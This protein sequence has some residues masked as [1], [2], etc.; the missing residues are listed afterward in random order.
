[1][2]LLR[3]FELPALLLVGGARVRFAH[4]LLRD[5]ARKAQLR[6]MQPIRLRDHVL[7]G[8]RLVVGRNRGILNA[9]RRLELFGRHNEIT[10][11]AFLVLELG[12]PGELARGEEVRAA[13]PGFQLQPLHLALQLLLEGIKRDARLGEGRLGGIRGVLPADLEGRLA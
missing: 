9:H 2:A 11:L 5:E 13:D 12:D 4:R 8:V 7:A 6:V 1:M 10:Q 3:Q